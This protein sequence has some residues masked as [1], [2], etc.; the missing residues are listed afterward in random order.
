MSLIPNELRSL[1]VFLSSFSADE[2]DHLIP[3]TNIVIPKMHTIFQ[4]RTDFQAQV[5]LDCIVV[6]TFATKTS[7]ALTF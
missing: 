4:A 5:M 6:I 1:N 3:T 2:D 7:N